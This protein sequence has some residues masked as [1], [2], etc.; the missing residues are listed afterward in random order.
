MKSNFATRI[1]IKS[2]TLSTKH[3]SQC[4]LRKTPHFRI[5]IQIT[6][7]YPTFLFT[8][9]C[10]HTRRTIVQQ[11][12]LNHPTLSIFRT[13]QHTSISFQPHY[14][15][16]IFFTPKHSI[17]NSHSNPFV[18]SHIQQITRFTLV[19][20]LICTTISLHPFQSHINILVQ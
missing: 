12:Y 20:Y 7:R 3:I 14:L 11:S 9:P 6:T 19:L 10:F 8:F 4:C 2:V 5:S 1:I 18:R 15:L 13:Y 17:L 16:A